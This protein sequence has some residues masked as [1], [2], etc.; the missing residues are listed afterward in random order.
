MARALAAGGLDVKVVEEHPQVGNPSCCAGIVGVRGMKALG[1]R[2]GGWV[3]GELKSARIFSPS[4]RSVKMGRGRSEAWII[5]RPAFDRWL[6]EEA[7]SAGADLYLSTRC[8]GVRPEV[9]KVKLSGL[10][11]GFVKP[12]VLVGADGAFSAVGRSAGLPVRSHTLCAQAE[13]LCE[14]ERGTAEIYLGRRFSAGFFAWRAWAGD[15]CRVGTGSISGSPIGQLQN[16]LSRFS[17]RKKILRVGVK[18]LPRTFL[19][20]PA[21]KRVLLVGDAAGQV[22]PLTGGGIFMGLFCADIAAASILRAFED[23]R[24]ESASALYVS[25]FKRELL[26]ELRI[27]SLASRLLFSLPDESLEKLFSL[28]EEEKFTKVIKSTF[29]FDYHSRLLRELAPL[30]PEI[31]RRLGLRSL[32]RIPY[33]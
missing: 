18:P 4:G 32:L 31:A 8:A 25:G 13:V 28:L 33:Q 21:S 6:A 7:A 10:K 23:G 11:S 30:L 5:D 14:A 9:P 16:L 19:P 2:R 1:F 29:D 26:R 17:G 15:T 22:K 20:S 24:P 3:V 12:S 27:S